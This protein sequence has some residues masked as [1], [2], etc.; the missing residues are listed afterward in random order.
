MAMNIGRNFL[1]FVIH[2]ASHKVI[3]GETAPTCWAAA[4]RGDD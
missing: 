2:D 3:S 1:V 4:C